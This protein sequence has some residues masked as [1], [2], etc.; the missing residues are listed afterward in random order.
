MREEKLL[1]SLAAAIRKR[2]MALKVSQEAFADLIGMHR[3]YYSAIER[4]ERNL[5][6]GTLHRVTKGLGVRMADL[7]RECNF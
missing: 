4:G 6:L 3:A 7:L 5:T 2:R 1:T